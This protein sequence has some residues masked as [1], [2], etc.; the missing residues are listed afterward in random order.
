[1]WQA[2][3]RLLDSR[4]EEEEGFCPQILYVLGTVPFPC[5]KRKN[6]ISLQMAAE[7]YSPNCAFCLGLTAAASETSGGLCVMI[8]F[9]KHFGKKIQVL[10]L[11]CGAATKS[12]SLLLAIGRKRLPLLYE[13]ERG[14][15]GFIYCQSTR[16]PFNSI[17]I[18]QI[19]LSLPSS[20]LFSTV[21]HVPP[22]V[23]CEPLDGGKASTPTPP[24]FPFIFP[25][26][27]PHPSRRPFFYSPP[28]RSPPARNSR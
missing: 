23:F 18:G 9:E 16:G 5:A 12:P 20:P 27:P 1:M 15:G 24:F 28:S 26:P 7:Y 8:F 6:E 21:H 13:V 22:L 10:K 17:S 14:G 3:V 11:N 19:G 2:S 25:S 4:V